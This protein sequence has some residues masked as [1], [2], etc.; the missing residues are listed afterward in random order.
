[1][2]GFQ[3]GGR[4]VRLGEKVQ[5]LRSI[6]GRYRIARY[7]IIVKTSVG[8][9]EGKELICTTHGHELRGVDF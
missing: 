5:G 6:T 4:R 3:L 2:D 9:G 7:R 8:N 1:M